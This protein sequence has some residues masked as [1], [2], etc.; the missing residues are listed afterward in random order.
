MSIPNTCQREI[1]CAAYARRKT[2]QDAR[3]FVPQIGCEK[4]I[5]NMVDSDYGMRYIV[6]WVSNP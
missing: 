5:V 6:V 3:F 1:F 4:L 2:N